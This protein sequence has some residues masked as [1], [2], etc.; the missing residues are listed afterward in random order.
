MRFR[1][2][3]R[4][5][6]VLGAFV[7]SSRRPVSRTLAH[8]RSTLT[9]VVPSILFIRDIGDARRRARVSEPDL[10]ELRNYLADPPGG[11]ADSPDACAAL[12]TLDAALDRSDEARHWEFSD[13]AADAVHWALERM[14][15]D[16]RL[17]S[18]DLHQ[19]R[20]VVAPS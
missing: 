7:G 15:A 10:L 4:R 11:I 18:A 2:A 6:G 3:S 5:P 16:N 20:N 17:L 1:L 9:T 13:P 8:C 14:L 12:E 19:L